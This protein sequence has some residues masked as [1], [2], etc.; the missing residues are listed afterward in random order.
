MKKLKELLTLDKSRNGIK[1]AETYVGTVT[2]FNSSSIYADMSNT[3]LHTAWATHVTGYSIPYS[4][5]VEEDKPL[6]KKETNI[7]VMFKDNSVE[8]IEIHVIKNIKRRIF[9]PFSK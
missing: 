8:V 7:F 4:A 3:K 9:K 2:N 1:V 5:V 6:I